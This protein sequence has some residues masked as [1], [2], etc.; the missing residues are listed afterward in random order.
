MKMNQH[1]IKADFENEASSASGAFD[2]I[3]QQILSSNLNYS[4]QLT[5][6]SAVISLKKSLIKDKNGCVILPSKDIFTTSTSETEGLK[7]RLDQVEN[8]LSIV[9]EKYDAKNKA[10]ET[11]MQKI[12]LLEKELDQK[13]V[14]KKEACDDVDRLLVE[15]ENFKLVVIEQESKINI[16]EKDIRKRDEEIN[17]L[18]TSSKHGLNIV[19]KPN[20]EINGLKLKQ[21]SSEIDSAVEATAKHNCD[22]VPQCVTRDPFPPPSPKNPFLIDPVSK[23]HEHMMSKHGPPAMF[24]GCERCMEPWRSNNYGCDSCIWL[25]WHGEK[26]GLPDIKPWSYKKHLET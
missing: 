13:T 7:L 4:L 14:I 16:L 6:F 9:K 3:L 23:Y 15:N 1:T 21:T 11:A 5:P 25:K 18:T 10:Y 12:Q 2:W 8:D 26:F 17:W 24:G 20:K 19:E 22:H